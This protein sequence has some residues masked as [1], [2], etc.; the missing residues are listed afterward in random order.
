MSHIH[1]YTGTLEKYAKLSTGQPQRLFLN[2]GLRPPKKREGRGLKKLRFFKPR[3][4]LF[5]APEGS[6]ST[7]HPGRTEFILKYHNS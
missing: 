4:S 7:Q 2:F 6:D 1:H 3:P 5:F